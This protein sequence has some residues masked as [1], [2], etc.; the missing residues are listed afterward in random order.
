LTRD[1]VEAA[2]RPHSESLPRIGSTM[3]RGD[4]IAVH[5]A[6]CDP[7]RHE[8]AITGTYRANTDLPE[9][10]LGIVP[11]TDGLLGVSARWRSTNPPKWRSNSPPAMIRA[12]R[13]ASLS[14]SVP[15]E[16]LVWPSAGR[17]PAT[18]RASAHSTASISQAAQQRQQ[19]GHFVG[20]LFFL[21]GAMGAITLYRIVHSEELGARVR[22]PR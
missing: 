6:S 4:A 14:P 8:F 3:L 12:L 17:G 18:E 11:T 20:I 10:Q 5:E 1:E 16:Y 22:G 15:S 2:C 21:L 19:V 9:I 7:E 13:A